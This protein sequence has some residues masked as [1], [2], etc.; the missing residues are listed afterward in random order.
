LLLEPQLL[1]ADEPTASLDSA[2]AVEIVALLKE[3]Q[4]DGHALLLASH[5]ANVVG[6]CELT[7]QIE[8]T[9][10]PINIHRFHE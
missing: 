7:I 6:A 10:K 1:I 3:Y 2:W 4:K 9:R 5:D 8:S